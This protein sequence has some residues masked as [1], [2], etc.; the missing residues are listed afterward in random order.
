MSSIPA[1]VIVQVNPGVISAGGS[2]LMLQ[3]LCVTNSSRVPLGSVLSFPSA[4]AVATFFGQGTPEAL[5]SAVYFNGF[6]NSNITPGGLLF[7]Q[8]NAAAA[9][10]WLQG[11]SVAGLTLTQL[12]ALTGTL[13]LTVGGTQFTSSAI[14]LSAATSFSSAATIIQAGF[15][16][17]TFTVTYDSVSG[18]FLFTNTVTGTASTITPC[19]GTL[20]VSLLLTVATGSTM[21]QGAPLNTPA[22]FMNSV[23]AAT[24]NWATFF[25]TFDPDNGSGNVLKQAFSAWNGLQNNNFLY[26]CSDPDITPTQSTSATTSLGY[27]LAQSQTSG[28]CVIYDPTAEWLNAFV[29][30]FV[31][32]LDFNQLNGRATLDFKSQSGLVP[33]VTNATIRSNLIANNYNFYGGY[34]TDNQNFV[35]MEPGS[36]SGVFKWLDSYVDQIWMNNAL[37]LS[38]MI[39]LTGVKSVPYNADGYALIRAACMTVIQQAVN[40]GA[41]RPGVP[42]SPLQAAEVN[43]AAGLAIDGILATQGWYLQILPATAQ[44]RGNRQSPPM[45]FWYMDGGSV[46]QISLAS[47]EV[48]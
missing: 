7:A 45:T 46:Q 18:G 13:I 32:S 47:L 19:T 4:Q 39:L 35:F 12:K 23:T 15:T 30:G 37:Q 17:P 42:L 48:M 41:I 29:A 40:F 43:Y 8:F 25:T 5:S 24:D 36:V 2:G 3:G 1:S 9:P 31:A 14:N 20:A 22:A 21:Q 16:A 11:G 10:G 26:A 44:T 33:T 27:L 38:L 28:T 6:T 34:A